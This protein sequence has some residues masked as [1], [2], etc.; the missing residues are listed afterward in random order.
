M[1][2]VSKRAGHARM[3][4]LLAAW[5]LF[6]FAGAEL[7]TVLPLIIGGLILTLA[8]R[9]RIGRGSLVLLDVALG[10]C[11]VVVAFQ[12]V[13]LPPAIRLALSPHV[14]AVDS[15]LWIDAP[16]DP[17]T[18]PA[19][20]LT[21]DVAATRF[22]LALAATFVAMF[23]SARAVFAR[24]GIRVVTRGLAGTGLLLAGVAIGQH[25]TAPRLLYW[26]WPTVF[27]A[28]FGPYLNRND[29]STWLIMAI[30][31]IVGYILTRIQSRHRR[32]S[33]DFDVEALADGTAVWLAM[34][35]CLTS[36]ALLTAVSRSALTGAAA[37]L[38]CFVW[39]SRNRTGHSGRAILLTGVAVVLGVAVA[40]ANLGAL[41]DRVDETLTVGMGGR[42]VIWRE[43]WQMA[44]DFWLTGTGAGTYARGMLVY[45]HEARGHFYFNHAHNEYLQ[46]AAEGGVLLCVPIAAALMA[47]AYEI[48]QRIR[49]DR[50]PIFWLRIGAASGMLAVAVQSVWDTGLRMPANAVLFALVAAIALHEGAPGRGSNATTAGRRRTGSRE[51]R[52]ELRASSPGVRWSGEGGLEQQASRRRMLQQRDDE[53]AVVIESRRASDQ[54]HDAV[55]RRELEQAVDIGV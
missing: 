3:I 28:P 10:M 39:L 23:W 46:F 5:T 15:A 6:A 41:A 9:P 47:G 25:A 49:H 27:G 14:G 12:L 19:G 13:L 48:G 52:P 26:H 33:T 20:P 31:L 16:R 11:L 42:R 37:A 7:W 53:L 4:V 45:Q 51:P 34:A 35:A 21:I 24:G 36:A 18:G 8:V 54:R 29:F 50:T 17:L 32:G 22:A 30:P 44:R 55:G 38:G 40:Y 1:K 2:P 43:T